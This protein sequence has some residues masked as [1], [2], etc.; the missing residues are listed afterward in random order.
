MAERGV[1]G[2]CVDDGV[3]ARRL[4]GCCWTL[5]SLCFSGHGP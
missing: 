5:E 4:V 2:C 3:G 1:N